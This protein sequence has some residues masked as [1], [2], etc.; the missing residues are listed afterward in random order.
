MPHRSVTLG[1]VAVAC[2]WACS[3]WVLS[4]VTVAS[5]SMAPTFCEGER[6]LVLRPGAGAAAA[7]GDVV[8]FDEPRTGAQWVK[9]VVAVEGQTVEVYDGRLLV[10]D[11]VVDEPY[12][13]HRTVDGT[14]TR[15]F[16][17]GPDSVF[18]LGDAREFAVDS[19]DF[20]P[21]SRSSV[22][23]RVVGRLWGRCAA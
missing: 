11:A 14:F 12:V 16:T 2:T 23:G 20:G 6:I 8:V 9:R 13:D 21:I 5:S 15:T 18:V 22:T 3:A 4:P 17:V 10:D 19:R 7:V 1:A